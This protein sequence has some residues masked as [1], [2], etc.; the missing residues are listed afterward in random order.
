MSTHFFHNKKSA[1][2]RASARQSALTHEN[3]ETKEFAEE[4]KELLGKLYYEA[5]KVLPENSQFRECVFEFEQKAAEVLP[6]EIDLRA[7]VKADTKLKYLHDQLEDL[8]SKIKRKSNLE[9]VHRLISPS[10]ASRP[11]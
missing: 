11:K 3:D 8:L 7:M 9:C 4:L 1:P 5:Y 2:K 6:Y 10:V